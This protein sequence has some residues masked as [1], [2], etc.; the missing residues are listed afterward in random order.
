MTSLEM[1][2]A[3]SDDLAPALGEHICW[4]SLLGFQITFD[5]LVLLHLYYLQ[6]GQ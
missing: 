3:S 2:F 5:K 4:K 6:P 1:V